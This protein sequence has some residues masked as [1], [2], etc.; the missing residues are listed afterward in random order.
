MNITKL[1]TFNGAFFVN[2]TNLHRFLVHP[3]E[4]KIL[5]ILDRNGNPKK[6]KNAAETEKFSFGVH[7]DNLFAS[8]ELAISNHERVYAEIRSRVQS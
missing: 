3:S 4:R 2:V 1:H 6:G 8:K 5:T 7:I